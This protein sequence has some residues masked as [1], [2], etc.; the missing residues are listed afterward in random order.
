MS[1]YNLE[2]LRVLCVDDSKFMQSTVKILLN[3]MGI[4]SVYCLS[5]V[6]DIYRELSTYEPDLLITD[7]I[8]EPMSGLELIRQLRN[9]EGDNWRFLPAI[10]L[11]GYANREVVTEARFY[12]GAD[13]V[14]VKP[15]S[16]KRLHNCIISIYNSTR[17]FVE[18]NGYFGPD[19]R[20]TDRPF[21]GSGRRREERDDPDSDGELFLEVIDEVRIDK[22]SRTR[23]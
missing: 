12:S 15:V 3:S 2:N 4:D 20:V 1:T 6:L 13:A 21:E 17:E 19:R 16:V 10:L 14:L 18:V 7:H 22:K 23:D 9:R 5:E 8:M 11:T